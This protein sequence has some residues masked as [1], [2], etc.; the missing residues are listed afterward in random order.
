MVFL[1]IKKLGKRSEIY[2]FFDFSYY[3]FMYK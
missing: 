1:S 2:T 3:A